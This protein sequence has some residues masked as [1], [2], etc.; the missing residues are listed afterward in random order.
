ME[1]TDTLKHNLILKFLTYKTY[2]FWHQLVTLLTGLTTRWHHPHW[3]QFWP[4]GGAACLALLDSPDGSE[5]ESS[6]ARVTSVKSPHITILPYYHIMMIDDVSDNMGPKIIQW[7]KEDFHL[8]Y[9]FL[10]WFVRTLRWMSIVS[11]EKEEQENSCWL[12]D[13]QQP[14]AAWQLL[15]AKSKLSWLS[16][17]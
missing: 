11:E 1:C 17:L 10:S 9:M 13:K 2:L 6:P 8:K 16:W 12:K 14:R 15:A 4:P 3:L 5:L 7:I